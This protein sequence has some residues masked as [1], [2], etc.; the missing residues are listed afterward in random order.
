[1]TNKHGAII[2][3]GISL[4]RNLLSQMYNNLL[5][6]MSTC[7]IH[8]NEIN[9]PIM[10]E[11]D[12]YDFTK[13]I[14]YIFNKNYINLRDFYRTKEET[15]L[16]KL[17]EEISKLDI[18]KNKLQEKMSI[19][20]SK[21]VEPN[22]VQSANNN[23]ILSFSLGDDT[24]I[25]DVFVYFTNLSR[26]TY[27]NDSSYGHLVDPTIFTVRPVHYEAAYVFLNSTGLIE[28]YKEKYKINATFQ[29]K[30]YTFQ[31]YIKPKKINNPYALDINVKNKLDDADEFELSSEEQ[32]DDKE[33]DQAS[34]NDVN[35]PGEEQLSVY[36][37]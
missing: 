32:L 30:L 21:N 26:S 34:A 17:L 13:S 8:T 31:E 19:M 6:N 9:D 27:K 35:E 7:N 28:L 29:W 24:K 22:L 3:F 25:S 5:I 23:E 4:P 11:D 36:E 20:F 1:M 18:Q 12:I 14:I 16:L 10:Y 33:N 2:G 15:K 37:M